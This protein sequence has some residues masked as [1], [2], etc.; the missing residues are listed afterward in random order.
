MVLAINLS[1]TV[2]GC[3]D[4]NVKNFGFWASMAAAV[5]V[6]FWALAHIANTIKSVQ[7]AFPNEKFVWTNVWNLI[8]FCILSFIGYVLS[9]VSE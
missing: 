6:L 1:L 2:W 3:F 5:T 9:I 7:N 4:T 8:F